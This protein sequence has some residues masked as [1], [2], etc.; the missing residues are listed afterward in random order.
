MNEMRLAHYTVIPIFQFSVSQL[1]PNAKIKA[2]YICTYALFLAPKIKPKITKLLKCVILLNK[3]SFKNKTILGTC[4][5]ADSAPLRDVP[6]EFAGLQHYSEGER[7]E[8]RRE[9]GG[10]REGGGRRERRKMRGRQRGEERE[11]EEERGR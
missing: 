4:A 8:G 3:R 1:Q 7:K 5:S 9:G 11:E 10:G 2:L 6:G